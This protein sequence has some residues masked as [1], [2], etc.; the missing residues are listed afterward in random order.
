MIK[1]KYKEIKQTLIQEGF[2]EFN[3]DERYFIFDTKNGV[4]D[5]KVFT[6]DRDEVLGF[7]VGYPL[8]KEG[9]FDE[10]EYD[11]EEAGY[12]IRKIKELE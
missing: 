10:V 4:L 2:D 6:D 9:E 5:L 1:T 8:E 11:P 3:E 12:M 7:K